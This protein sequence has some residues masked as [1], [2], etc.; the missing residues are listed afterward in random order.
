VDARILCKDP[1]Y[2][3]EMAKICID[4]LRI[5]FD[6]GGLKKPYSQSIRYAAEYGL[7]KLSNYMLYNFH[8]TPEDLYERMRLNIDLN[9][10]L[11]IRIFSFPMRYQPVTLKDRSH[12]GKN[13][14]R[15]FLR[16][17][18]LILQ[19]TH[20]IVSGSPEYFKRAFGENGLSYRELL[21]RPHHFIFNRTWYEVYG[22][23]A[24][25]E[26][27]ESKF[28]SLSQSQ[29]DELIE[30][31]SSGPPSSRQESFKHIKPGLLK[32][33]FSHYLPLGFE[34]ESKIWSKMKDYKSKDKIILVPDDERVE[35]AGLEEVC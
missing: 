4:P 8:D 15:Y 3:R 28:H 31:L 35:D 24:E 21:S 10:E 16:S 9:E 32:D 18:Q 13:W 29:K 22:G 2:L 6:H 20:G 25:F 26:E 7:T 5:A 12:V 23:K 1:M 14:N 34:L 33:V 30:I 11:G 17:M 27:F 19:A